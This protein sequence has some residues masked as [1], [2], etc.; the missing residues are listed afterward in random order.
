M[1][2]KWIVTLLIGLAAGFVHFIWTSRIKAEATGGRKISVLVAAEDLTPDKTVSK[3]SFATR[4][5]PVAY[6]DKRDAKTEDLKKFTGLS[7]SVPINKGDVIQWTDFKSRKGNQNKDLAS[8]IKPGNRAITISVNSSLSLGGLLKPG[9]RVDIFGTFSRAQSFSG[10]KRTVTLLQ[11]VTVLATGDTIMVDD[12]EDASGRGRFSTVT[13]SVT[14][15]QGEMLA[16]SSSVGILSLVL[17]GYE[18]LA[19][20]SD[21]P[22]KGFNDIWEADRRNLLQ[23]KGRKIKT[24][25]ERIE[26]AGF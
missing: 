7:P 15:E 3:S 20:I 16:F 25:I 24:S 1:T 22:E 8:F 26:R 13:L 11:N 19:V 21:I 17:R 23:H 4:L 5:I 2:S 12:D 9:H 10:E 6:V 18:D 14:I